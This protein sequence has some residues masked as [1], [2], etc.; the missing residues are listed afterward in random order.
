MLCY[1]YAVAVCTVSHHHGISTPEVEGAH[2]EIAFFRKAGRL[3]VHFCLR[4]K[5]LGTRSLFH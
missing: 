1:N 5:Y 4:L 2:F 3:P